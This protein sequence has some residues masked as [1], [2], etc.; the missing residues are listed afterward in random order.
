MKA[1][2]PRRREAV[3]IL[4][5]LLNEQDPLDGSEDLTP[6]LL[7]QLALVLYSLQEYD[8]SRGYCEDLV[9]LSPDN[10]Q[11]LEL[12][13]A[14]MFRHKEQEER[15]RREKRE[16]DLQTAGIATSVGVA[17]LF[18]IGAIASIAMKSG[19]RK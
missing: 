15:R 16:R 2:V 7:Y 8:A 12:H 18:A 5:R 10:R 14:V 6:T 11:F 4:K 1:S 3:G 19:K 17:A 13:E 9:G